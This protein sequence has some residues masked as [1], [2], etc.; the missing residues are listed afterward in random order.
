MAII[1]SSVFRSQCYFV[2][3]TTSLQSVLESSIGAQRLLSHPFYR[4]WE[5]GELSTDELRLY[6]EQYRFFEEML[7][8]FLEQ[9]AEDLPEGFARDSV[10]KNLSD[11]IAPPSHLELFER[12]AEFYGATDADVSPAMS[13]LLDAYHDVLAQ[14]TSSALAGLWGV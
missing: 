14:G 9:L 11:E 4:R 3:M 13:G 7:P 10:L 2:S 1:T 12:F 6:A 8:R 5:A